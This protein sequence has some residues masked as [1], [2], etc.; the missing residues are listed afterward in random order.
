MLMERVAFTG[1][2]RSFCRA[3]RQCGTCRLVR[4]YM[5]KR[6][7]ILICYAFRVINGPAERDIIQETSW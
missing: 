2:L 4:N 3:I 7:I 6:R 1:L 5:E